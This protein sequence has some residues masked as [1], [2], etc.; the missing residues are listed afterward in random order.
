MEKYLTHVFFLVLVMPP[1]SKKLMGHV[2]LGLSV[3]GSVRQK[4]CMLG[5]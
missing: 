5:F 3:R 2:S 4:T 1:T